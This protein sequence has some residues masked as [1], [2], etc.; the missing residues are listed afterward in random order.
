[1]K[2]N[3]RENAHEKIGAFPIKTNYVHGGNYSL[4]V[5]ILF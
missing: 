5:Q 4:P 1:M 2:I 3:N